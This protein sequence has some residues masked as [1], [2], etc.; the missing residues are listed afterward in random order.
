M[1][2]TDRTVVRNQ[3]YQKGGIG[4]RERHNERKNENY[5]NHDIELERSPMNVHFRKCDSTYTQAL[6]RMIE[7]KTVSTRGLK[8][9]AKVFE[10]MVFDVNTAYFENHGGYEYAKEFFSE[11]FHFAEKELGSKYI[12]SAVMHADEKNRAMSDDL[13]RSVYHYH[14]HV[15]Y[16]P[17]VEKEVRWTKKCKD[18][19]LVGTVKEVVC[20]ISHSK[21]WAFSPMLDEQGN[22]ALS[23]AGKPKRIPSYSLLQDR[24][25]EHMQGAGYKDFERGV[26]GSTEDN[27]SVLDYKIKQDS[28]RL[29]EITKELSAVQPI[30]ADF[31]E[32]SAIGK[33]MFLNG[34]IEI[35]SGEY[36][37]LKGLAI[38]GVVAGRKIISLRKQI[39]GLEQRIRS[40]Q[41]E[42]DSLYD[43]TKEF[44][45]AVKLAPERVKELFTDIFE[46]GKGAV[47]QRRS[48][49]SA[50][51]S[52]RDTR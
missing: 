31:D 44:F 36:E 38:D 28:K 2:K 24:F 5:S 42:L 50:R 35:T 41:K 3:P 13:G 27:L 6:E 9:D 8:N 33:R 12:L 45:M 47:D 30:K 21:K 7:E 40:Q 10:E 43:K 23:S 14:L 4:I 32:V 20:Q 52:G 11:A 18:K 15:I 19:A 48:G 29:G 17:V 26:R 1:A 49:L 22:P 16:I 46:K 25:F 51:P 39:F 34:N 37:R